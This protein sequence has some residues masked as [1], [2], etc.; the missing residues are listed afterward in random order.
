MTGLIISGYD[1]DLL[2]AR[3]RWQIEREIGAN[4]NRNGAFHVTVCR[5]DNETVAQKIV[6]AIA[7]GPERVTWARYACR[8]MNRLAREGGAWVV[9]WCEPRDK[10]TREPTRALFLWKDRDGDVPVTFDCVQ[11]FDEIVAMGPTWFVDAG[12]RALAE[13][14]AHNRDIGVKAD[15]MIKEALG[16][17]S[18]NPRAGGPSAV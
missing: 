7:P 17:Q 18:A 13:Y 5:T 12:V 3:L 10:I 8:L 9:V 16:Q 1:D 14:R 4:G 6:G 2:G 11:P 15:Q